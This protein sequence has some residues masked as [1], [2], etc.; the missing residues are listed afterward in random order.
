LR[1][2]QKQGRVAVEAASAVTAPASTIEPPAAAP[3]PELEAPK[4][5]P[6]QEEPVRQARA[7]SHKARQAEASWSSLVSAGRFARVLGAAE[8]RGLDSVYQRASLDDLEALADAARY[9]QRPSVA[10]EALTA[11]RRRFAGTKPAKQA[12]FLLGR[13][14]EDESAPSALQWYDRYLAEEPH[15]I[16]ASQALGRRMLILYRRGDAA[17]AGSTAREYLARFPDGPH[18]ESARKIVTGP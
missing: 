7:R 10:R 4:A 12:A 15:G 8:E 14:V 3:P 17:Q 18:A 2:D 13:L 16:H 11:M 9:A 5:L 6:P 1:I